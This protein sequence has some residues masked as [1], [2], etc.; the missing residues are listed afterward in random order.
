MTILCDGRTSVQPLRIN[1]TLLLWMIMI[2][3]GTSPFSAPENPVPQSTFIKVDSKRCW[4]VEPL[5]HPTFSAAA[6]R[7]LRNVVDIIDHVKVQSFLKG[8]CDR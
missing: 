1:L 5:K 3:S 4:T 2:G 8:D 7:A 6:G